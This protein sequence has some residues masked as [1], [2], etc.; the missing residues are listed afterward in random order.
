M[1]KAPRL[2][3]KLAFFYKIQNFSKELARLIKN[4]DKGVKT[5]T[6]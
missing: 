6:C 4:L 3:L 1:Q 2:L 5:A